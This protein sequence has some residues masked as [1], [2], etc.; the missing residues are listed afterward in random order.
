MALPSGVRWSLA[1]LSFVGVVVSHWLAYLVAAPDPHD[2]LELLQNTG[3][4]LWSVVV[5]VAMGALVWSLVDFVLGATRAS[6]RRN[7]SLSHD[8]PVTVASLLG[9]QEGIFLA[10]ESAERLVTS[11][12]VAGLLQEP[13]VIAG[14]L[15]QIVVAVAGAL[16]LRALAC[17]VHKVLAGGRSPVRT[18]AQL[19]TWETTSASVPC[20]S[21]AT[22]GPTL[23]GPPALL[24]N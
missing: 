1:G 21:P 17:V 4:R 7:S 15:I 11:G 22:G 19:P 16:L 2:R 18:S 6:R 13:A 14:L 12:S 3:H 9:L 8:L 24:S 20:I 5:A 23:R 10:L